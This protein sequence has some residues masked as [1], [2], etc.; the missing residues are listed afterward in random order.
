MREGRAAK[1]A[2]LNIFVIHK[3]LNFFQSHDL[4]PGRQRGRFLRHVEFFE[5][6]ARPLRAKADRTQPAV[7]PSCFANS[8]A[9]RKTSSSI[10]KN[11]PHALNNSALT[12][13]KSLRHKGV[14]KGILVAPQWLYFE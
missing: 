3:S 4:T 7:L 11:R 12:R 10:S 9:T 5:I 14:P 6:D 13:P 2:A 8:S 1:S